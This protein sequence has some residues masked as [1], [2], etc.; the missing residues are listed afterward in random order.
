MLLSERKGN[1]MLIQFS[2]SNYMSIKDEVTLSML[3]GKDRE[4]SD[5]LIDFE[6]E[7]ILSSAG[8]YGANAAGKS[9]IFKALTAAIIIARTSNARQINEKIPMIVPFKFDD[10]SS[11]MPTSFG[12]I[13][14]NNGRKYEYGFTADENRVYEE[15]L[16]EYKTAKPSKVF[17]RTAISKYEFIKADEKEFNGYV[18]KNTD[19][20]LFLATATAW[21]CERTKDAYMW[22]AEGID[23]YN[24]QSLEGAAMPELEN[25]KDGSLE[26]FL[27]GML[28]KADI[29]ISGYNFTTKEITNE[30][31]SKLPLPPGIEI[32]KAIQDKGIGAIKQY[33]IVTNH[34]IKNKSGS[35][36]YALPFAI[37]SEGT[38]RLFFFSPVIKKAMESG[39]TVVV[40]EI[41][42]SLH[43]LLVNAIIELFND[44]EVNTKGAQLIFNTHDVNLL[45]LDNF[46][47]DQIYFTEKD[48]KTGVTDL[49]SLD[50]FS[51]R[52]TENI[53]KGY[54]QGRYGAI[55]VIEPG[56]LKW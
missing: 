29:N 47:R 6:K 30:D 51:P 41:D 9:N 43:P 28:H 36:N 18:G 35:K 21:N 17:E 7:C 34:D 52:K 11:K 23:T 3:A 39:K 10:E 44:K 46:R 48:N 53:R 4:H 20:K 31:I 54:L 24:S 42:D 32:S 8:I 55:P 5:S 37:E 12:F 2:V 15:Y 49:Y 1:N 13:F 38:K 25:D 40:D 22:L 50:E 33:E 45:S 26:A 19:N 27:T 56:G 16:Y 14:T